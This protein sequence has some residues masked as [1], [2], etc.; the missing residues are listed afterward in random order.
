MD[1]PCKIPQYVVNTE[2]PVLPLSQGIDWGLVKLNIKNLHDKGITGRGVNIVVLDTGI[3]GNHPD[4]EVAS[5]MDFTGTGIQ[6][7]VGHGTHVAGIIS[8]ENNNLGMMGVAFDCNLHSYKVLSTNSGNMADVARAI[9]TAADNGM[10]IINMS[11]G[12]PANVREVENAC[13]YAYDQGCILVVS[14]GNSGRNEKFYPAAYDYCLSVGAINSDLK[15][16]GFSSYGQ[17]LDIMAPG[18]KILSTYL[19]KGYAVLSG[20]SM[21]APFAT[22]CIALMKQAGAN[23]SYD[24]IMKSTIDILDPNFDIRSGHGILD[25][26]KAVLSNSEPAPDKVKE[27]ILELE[28]VTNTLK[29]LLL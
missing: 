14:S 9:R 20:T 29:Q 22:A 4:L 25:P 15:V 13:K 12:S 24:A 17:H 7:R 21:A 2:N 10:E 11:L 27:T 3:D 5:H 23:I 18:E 8:A 1:T 16:S 19:N 6:D 28:Q 26:N